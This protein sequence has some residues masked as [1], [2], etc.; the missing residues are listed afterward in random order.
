MHKII[1][2]VC[3]VLAG[4]GVLYATGP[5]LST[6]IAAHIQK[7]ARQEK[8]IRL[9]HIERQPAAANF[10]S[11]C[12]EDFPNG[13]PAKVTAPENLDV[14][15]CDVSSWN[16]TA[17]SAR[18][19]SDVLT[20][21]S[22]TKLPPREK[23]P[24]GFSA[25]D[26]LANG[27]NPG[28][29][30][31]AL[32]AQGI[33]GRGVSVAIIDQPLLTT[34]PEYARSL[35]WYE[36]DS[37]S[38][39]WKASMHG[40]AVASL[41]AG[42]TVGTAPGVRLFFFA[43]SF[44]RSNDQQYDAAPI[45]HM[46]RRIAHLN[47]LLPARQ[48]I[49]VVSISRGFN[50]NNLDAEEFNAAKKSLEDD[51]VAVFTTKDVFTLSRTHAESAPDKV[52]NYCRP[53]YWFDPEEL[54]IY[55]DIQDITVPTDF[56]TTAAPN[57]NG[58]YVHYAQG[59]LSWAV[60]YAAG[61]YALGAQVNPNLTKEMFLNAARDSAARRQCEYQGKQFTAQLVQPARLIARLKEMHQP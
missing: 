13:Q 37:E 23:L 25:A 28:L 60:P 39:G 5:A 26:I 61:L 30:V 16:F 11:N 45:A 55:E 6:R 8:K 2:V 17:Y 38:S 12:K 40:G 18:E 15:S 10:S 31:R 22:K 14:R 54:S 9:P 56:R 42:Q 7:Q 20:F 36:E 57:G 24:E 46:L 32:H 3:V 34:H 50:A 29:G 52:Q 47:T 49:R 21:D 43:P 48:K 58:D 53:A 59:G 35:D 51:G 41:L 33:T 19:L 44:G 27:K 4:A 1:S